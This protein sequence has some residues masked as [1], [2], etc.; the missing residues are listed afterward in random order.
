MNEVKTPYDRFQEFFGMGPNGPNTVKS[1]VRSVSVDIVN[2]DRTL[3]AFTSPGADANVIAPM[4]I[5]TRQVTCPRTFERMDL[6]YE[7]LNNIRSIGKNADPGSQAGMSYIKQQA[8]HMLRRTR[9]WREFLLWGMLRGSCQFLISGNEWVPVLSGGTVTLDWQVS[10]NHKGQL[11]GIIDTSWD[12][13]A[14]SIIGDLAAISAQSEQDCG[15]PITHAWC[16]SARWVKI[17]NNTEVRNLGGTAQEPFE[18]FQSMVRAMPNYGGDGTSVMGIHSERTGVLRGFPSII[19]HITDRGMKV[20]GVFTKFFADNEVI[21]HPDPDGEWCFG[22][23]VKESTNQKYGQPPEDI[24]GYGSWIKFPV[25]ADT[26]K[27]M[28]YSLDNFFPAL[29]PNAV[30][31]ANVV[32]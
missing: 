4:V 23:E 21:F 10:S 19:W 3:S 32:P 25:D 18:L 26:P 13:A 30:F 28:L 11:N 1:E 2:D 17:C 9:R 15:L 8:G 12:N 27:Y 16:N 6:S 20:N 22:Y 5:G 29:N 24:Y 7:R 14:A 31:F